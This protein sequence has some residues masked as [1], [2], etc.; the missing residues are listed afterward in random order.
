MVSAN[1][2]SPA[3]NRSLRTGDWSEWHGR[4]AH[5]HER[6]ARAMYRLEAGFYI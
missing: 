6:D 2:P 1:E 3:Y 5:D 4:L